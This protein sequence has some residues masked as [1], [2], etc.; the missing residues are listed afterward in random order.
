MVAAP[1]RVAAHIIRKPVA[2]SAV[3]E[4]IENPGETS[5]VDLRQLQHML[6]DTAA[7][8]DLETDIEICAEPADQAPVARSTRLAHTVR[9]AESAPIAPEPDVTVEMAVACEPEE[10]PRHG[11][12]TIYAAAAVVVSAIGLLLV[13]LS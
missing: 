13:V 8:I 12:A 10:A 2:E 3:C 5:R 9:R 1:K 6:A 7:P 4:V 11:R